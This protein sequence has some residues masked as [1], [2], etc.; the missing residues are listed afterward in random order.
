MTRW[1]KIVWLAS[2]L[3]PLAGWAALVLF[4]LSVVRP[5]VGGLA[6][7]GDLLAWVVGLC[8]LL[9]FA[10]HMLVMHHGA[11]GGHFSRDEQAELRWKLQTGRGHS[12]WRE[13]MR[14]HQRTWYKGRSHS[15]ERPRYD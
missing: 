1:E 13:L 4:G 5:S 8:V 7:R 15:G 14:K 3:A 12:R 9:A 2:W 6:A 10:A 11:T